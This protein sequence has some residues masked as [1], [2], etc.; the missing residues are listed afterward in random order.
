MK[1]LIDL[2]FANKIPFFA[3]YRKDLGYKSIFVDI[4]YLFNFRKEKL[5][6][7]SNTSICFKVEIIDLRSIPTTHEK[8]FFKHKENMLKFIQI[9]LG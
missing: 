2:G 8:K 1:E 9:S 7:D 5:E 3:N 4:C 6:D